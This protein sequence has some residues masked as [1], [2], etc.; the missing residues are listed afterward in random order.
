[1]FRA[2]PPDEVLNLW[3][4]V[5]PGLATIRRR[6]KAPWTVEQIRGHLLQARASLFVHEKGF[7]IVEK[8]V[9]QWTQEPYLNAWLM[10]FEPGEAMKRRDELVAWL[11]EMQRFHRCAWWQFGSPR[12][13]W[14]KAIES[15][16]EVTMIIWRR[17]K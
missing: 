15:F 17:R 10:W 5:S 1:M 11:D 14:A 16:C 12:K 6:C 4:E 2:I 13:E 3:A 9:E 8:C 7:V